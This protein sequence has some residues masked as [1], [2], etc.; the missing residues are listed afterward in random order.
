MLVLAGSAQSILA[1]AINTAA[2]RVL[3]KSGISLLVAPTAGCCGALSYHLSA[4]ADGLDFMR[5]NI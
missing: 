4:Q 2:T 1:P 3:N 5:R